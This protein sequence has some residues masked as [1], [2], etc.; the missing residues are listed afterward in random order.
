VGTECGGSDAYSG[1][2]ANPALGVAS[3]EIVRHGGTAILSETPEMYGAEHLLF[4]RARDESTAKALLGRIQWWERHVGALGAEINNNPTPGNILGGI[5]TI[6]EKSLG[7]IMKGGTSALNAVYEYAQPVSQK[8]FVIMDTPGYDPVSVTGMVAGGA[9]VIVFTTGRGSVHGS[10]PAPCLKVATN[11]PL[12]E[13]MSQDMDVNAGAIV[14]GVSV[15]EV[16]KAIFERI[17]ATA[18]GEKTASEKQEVGE[19]EFA[20]WAIGPVL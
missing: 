6:Y 12:Y 5:T 13:R 17:L 11:T 9:N 4:R 1:I 14:E 7:A 20:P 10:V 15:E 18:S 3:D 8:G 16:G 19:E 2:T